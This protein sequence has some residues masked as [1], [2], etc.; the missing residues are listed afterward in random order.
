MVLEQNIG[1]RSSQI[2]SNISIS[3]IHLFLR[4]RQTEKTFFQIVD[5]LAY[6]FK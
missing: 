4:T 3:N 5:V 6:G 1:T 2:F